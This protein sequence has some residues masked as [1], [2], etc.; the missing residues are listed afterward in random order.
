MNICFYTKTNPSAANLLNISYLM[1]RFPEHNYSFVRIVS[2]KWTPPTFKEKVKSWYVNK[3]FDDGRFDYE[4][5]QQ[6]I[7]DTLRTHTTP[8]NFKDFRCEDVMKVNDTASEQAM[9]SIQP[10]IIIQAGA[11]IV[12]ENIF[13][14][15]RIATINVHHGIAPEI[16]GIESTFWCLFYGL[17]D[18]IGVTCHF[19]DEKLDTGAVIC[20]QALQT[21][22]GTFVDVQTANFLMGREVLGKSVAILTKENFRIENR[23]QVKSYYFGMPDNFLYYGLKKRNFKPLMKISQ[24]AFTMKDLNEVV[25]P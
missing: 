21:T 3:R 12:N 17:N 23:G 14:K 24:R 19:I 7:K 9:M 10:D 15:A 5:D 25:V 4:R 11:G 20:K 13:T 16:R 22:T 8:V 18:M 1:N 6:A 2:A